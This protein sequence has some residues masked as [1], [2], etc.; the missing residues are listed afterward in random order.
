MSTLIE[1]IKEACSTVSQNQKR[2]YDKGYKD[3]KAGGGV[4]ATDGRTAL[5]YWYSGLRDAHN[6]RA[7]D[8]GAG[9][10]NIV[11]DV[12]EELGYPEKT[13]S[14]T[15]FN[16]FAMVCI[17]HSGGLVR[18]GAFVKKFTGTLDASNATELSHM[19]GGCQHL[20][21]LGN[22]IFGDKIE[23]VTSMFS[24]CRAL[25]SASAINTVNCKSFD[26]MYYDCRKITSIPELNTSNGIVLRRLVSCCTLLTTMPKLDT[27]KAEDVSNMFS[28]CISMVS[29][30]ELDLRSATLTGNMFYN[31]RALVSLRIKNLKVSTQIG[32]GTSYGHLIKVEDLIFT[33]YHLRDRGEATPRTLTVGTK[34]LQKLAGVYVKL[35]PITDEMRAEDDLIDEKKPFEVCESTDDGAML[36][37]NYVSLKHWALK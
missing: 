20:E 25:K 29:I 37:T 27:A 28:E 9:G 5:P 36:I 30:P 14:V 2:L 31:C 23:N 16:R 12:I 19:F 26:H 32:L 21:D 24:G 35:V 6:W 33:I 7:E 11:G 17:E 15:S 13:G 3:G 1:Q 4:T 10:V 22:V 8:D 34:N 18:T